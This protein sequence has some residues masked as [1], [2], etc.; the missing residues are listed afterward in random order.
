MSGAS[1]L[2]YREFVNHDKLAA[3]LTK[4]DEAKPMKNLGRAI[5]YFRERAEMSQAALQQAAGWGAGNSRINNYE[6]GNREPTLDD[7]QA[8]ARALGVKL[9]KLL[10]F[11]EVG[12]EAGT[13]VLVGAVE[14]ASLIYV[15]RIF[16]AHLRAGTGEIIYDMDE[17]PLS[18]AYDAEWMRAEGLK[19]EHCKV[20]PVKGDSMF[21]T[22]PSGAHVLL[23]MRSREPR[24]NRVFALVG[25]DGLRLKRLLRR[26]DGAWEIHSD[27]PLKSEFPTENYVP[28][29]VAIFGQV[30]DV[31]TPMPA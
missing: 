21:P 4:C 15:D 2:T 25:E 9:T 8:I 11:A 1:L 24:H 3:G 13:H 30:R 20:W 12:P 10:E 14:N 28:G 16:G 23:D 22:I 6:K 7:L 29:K 27:N 31:S 5:R 18:R 19:A 17:V 26:A